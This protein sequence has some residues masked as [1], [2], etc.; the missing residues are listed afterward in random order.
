MRTLHTTCY[1]CLSLVY[2]LVVFINEVAI[3]PIRTEKEWEGK[4]AGYFVMSA[5]TSTNPTITKGTKR[6]MSYIVYHVFA[7]RVTFTGICR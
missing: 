5:S 6:T 2:F 3:I 4:E 1:C 7:F